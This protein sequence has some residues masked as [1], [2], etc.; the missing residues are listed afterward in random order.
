M[1]HRAFGE[2]ITYTAGGNDPVAKALAFI[3]NEFQS[4]NIPMNELVLTRNNNDGKYINVDFKQVHNGHE[5]LWSRVGVRFSQDLKIV[6]VTLDAH[7]NVPQLNAAISPANAILNAEKSINT[8]I[9]NTTIDPS[10]KIFPYPT[11]GKFEYKL[12]YVVNVHTQDDNVTPG[13]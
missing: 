10:L 7:R 2:P 4:F 13:N 6:M 9:V 8:P 11:D 5:I 3:Q 12:V 1:P